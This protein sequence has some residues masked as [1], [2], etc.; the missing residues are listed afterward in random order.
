MGGIGIFLAFIVPSLFFIDFSSSTEIAT[1]L[2]FVTLI[3][4]LGIVDDLFRLE[5]SKK[6]IGQLLIIVAFIAFSNLR[7]DTL[8]HIVGTGELSYLVSFGA[9]LFVMIIVINSLNLVDGIDGLAGVIAIIS[10]LSFGIWFTLTGNTGYALLLF[11][12]S[13]GI[14]GFIFF[15]WEPSKIFMG[16]TGSLVI[17]MI[18]SIAAIKFINLNLPVSAGNYQVKAPIATTICLL[19][20]PLIDTAR[21]IILRLYK[22]QSPLKPDKNHIHHTLLKLGLS[23]RQASL[24]L[25][26]VHLIFVAISILFQ[27]LR[28]AILLPGII[29][30]AISLCI[31]LDR[32]V[33]KS[34]AIKEVE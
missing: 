11:A 23:H 20:I 13:G 4:A 8:H 7:L 16:D 5:A 21:I 24:L 34:I 12:L 10:S 14:I 18:L 25:G 1:V 3:F 31:F 9:T 15:N 28:D 17:G 2:L 26:S 19:S 6:L 33:I 32:K 27:D 30:L 22:K 29:I